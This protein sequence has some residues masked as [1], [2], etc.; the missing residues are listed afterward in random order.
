MLASSN[1]NRDVEKFKMQ[2][3]KVIVVLLLL[4]FSTVLAMSENTEYGL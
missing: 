4:P 3:R 1:P 2:H